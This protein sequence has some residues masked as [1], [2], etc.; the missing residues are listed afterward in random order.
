[1]RKDHLKNK[2]GEKTKS[3]QKKKG[4]VKV[5]REKLLDEIFELALENDIN[6]FG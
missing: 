1:M 2:R 4:K 5:D 6:Y 3:P